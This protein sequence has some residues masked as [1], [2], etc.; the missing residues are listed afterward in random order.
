MELNKILK[1][2]SKRDS[3]KFYLIIKDS[4][5]E[6]YLDNKQVKQIIDNFL[7][8][9]RLAYMKLIA[10]IDLK[11]NGKFFQPYIN[12]GSSEKKLKKE[13]LSNEILKLISKNYVEI[14]IKGEKV[15]LEYKKDSISTSILYSVAK[16]I[17]KNLKEGKTIAISNIQYLARVNSNRKTP[18]DKA[19]S[20][21]VK[22]FKITD[23]GNNVKTITITFS[24]FKNALIKVELTMNLTG[25]EFPRFNSYYNILKRIENKDYKIAYIGIGYKEKQGASMLISYKF[26][27]DIN[28]SLSDDKVMGIDLGQACLVYYAITNS[29]SRGDVSLS[30]SWKDKII[31]IWSKKKYLQKTLMEA[32]KQNNKNSTLYKK[33]AK[34]LNAIRDYEKNFMETMNKQIASKLI[35]IAVKEKVKTIVLEDLSLSNEKKNSLAFPKWNYYQLQTFIQNKAQEKGIEVKKINP[36]YTS[37]RCPECG[38]IGYYK[39]MTRP[40]RDKFTCPVCKFSEHADYVASLNIAEKDIEEKI[41]NRLISDIQRYEEVKEENVFILFK[42]RNR[43]VKELIKEFLNTEKDGLKELLKTLAKRNQKAYNILIR[44]FLEFKTT[45]IDKKE[46]DN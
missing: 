3:V 40:K 34:E 26:T 19:F 21:V 4:K 29:H 38:F 10:K 42:I 41:K 23:K 6:I 1:I 9:V 24:A 30:Y 8:D 22:E 7:D 44:D 17:V 43:I 46:L 20:Q 16:D 15:A 32:K 36:A 5:E 25:K 31:R 11:K 35:D 33:A 45:Y 18:Y 2:T 12:D 14:E 13:N 28:N 37:Q 27:Q 39:E